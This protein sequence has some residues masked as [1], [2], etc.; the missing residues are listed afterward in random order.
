[1]GGGIS[2]PDAEEVAKALRAGQVLPDFPMLDKEDLSVRVRDLVAAGHRKEAVFL[3]RSEEKM[4]QRAV[5][6]F[7]DSVAPGSHTWL[8]DRRDAW[9]LLYCRAVRL[10]KSPWNDRSPGQEIIPGLGFSL[11]GV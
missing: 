6:G 5:E 4:R 8:S 3:V 11:S 2:Q 7:V 9:P 1:M 10:A